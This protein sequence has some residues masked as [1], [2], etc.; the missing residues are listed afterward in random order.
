MKILKL[1]PETLDVVDEYNT[2]AAAA[3]SVNASSELIRMATK[4]IHSYKTAKGYRWFAL[5]EKTGLNRYDALKN[6]EGSNLSLEEM[7]E[8]LKKY[9]NCDGRRYVILKL[10]PE[11]LDVV[12]TYNTYKEIVEIYGR[13][14]AAFRFAA[15]DVQ[16]GDIVEGYRWFAL[17]KGT[18][19]NHY[20][21]P[22]YEK[23]QPE[24]GPYISL[25]ELKE[26]LI[27]IGEIKESI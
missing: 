18:G 6:K 22:E 1:D 21:Y 3:R 16:R 15:R 4:E 12:D 25:E 27:K 23:V 8:L 26:I 19:L 9:N 10:D 13:S 14:Q 17:D 7:R 11:T 2:Y 24:N 20:K 5:D